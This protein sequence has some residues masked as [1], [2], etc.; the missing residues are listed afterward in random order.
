MSLSFD[1]KDW[2]E[3]HNIASIIKM[4]HGDPPDFNAKPRMS[5]M[6]LAK[7]FG[8]SQSR[9][10]IYLNRFYRMHNMDLLEIDYGRELTPRFVPQAI[11]SLSNVSITDV[12]SY[13]AKSEN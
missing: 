2:L 7:A 3:K 9:I 12:D 13:V 4:R 6:A 1:Y 11:V 5:Q 8:K 10:S